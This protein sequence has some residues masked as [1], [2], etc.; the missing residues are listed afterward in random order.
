MGSCQAKNIGYTVAL[1]G[2]ASV[3]GLASACG[4]RKPEVLLD[5]VNTIVT[6]SI[7]DAFNICT[8]SDFA[9]LNIQITCDPKIEGVSFSVFEGNPSCTACMNGVFTGIFDHHEREQALWAKSDVRVRLPIDKEY[10]DMVAR[11]ELCGLSACKACVLSN[12]TQSSF[13]KSSNN[14]STSGDF[15]TTVSDNIQSNISTQLLNNQDVLAGVAS[16]LG[17]SD[18]NTISSTLRDQVVEQMKS[19]F[20]TGLSNQL[21]ASQSIIV[22]SEIG[23][24]VNN[25]VQSS[26]FAIVN[27]WV[28]SQD[29]A[30]KAFTKEFVD[31]VSSVAENQNTLGNVGELL[32]Q[33]SSIMAKTLDSIVGKILIAVLI[34]L[35]VI[36]VAIVSFA[37]YRIIKNTSKAISWIE[38]PTGF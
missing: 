31:A 38:R 3:T 5:S 26:M 18:L 35:L 23:I 4:P 13:I 20:Y 7:T 6:D 22:N 29:V 33:S 15:Q 12:S 10:Q 2:L 32:V 28:T 30:S 14:C 34:L 1:G 17:N 8:Q 19:D 27:S 11:L 25:V 37:L 24:S 21:N 36:V 9:K 16:A